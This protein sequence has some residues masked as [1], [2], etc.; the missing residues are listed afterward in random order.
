MAY[1]HEGT[2][3]DIGRPDDYADANDRID[4]LMMLMGLEDEL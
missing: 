4:E 3:L 2:W 1:P